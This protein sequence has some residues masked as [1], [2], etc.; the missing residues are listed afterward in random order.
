[1]PGKELTFQDRKMIQEGIEHN[2]SLLS[3]A[4]TI[5]KHRSTVLR[6]IQRNRVVEQID[7]T[8]ICQYCVRNNRCKLKRNKLNLQCASFEELHCISLIEAPYCCNGC[9]QEHLCN[10]RKR[11]YVAEDAQKTAERNAAQKR[12]GTRVK[13]DICH[14]MDRLVSNGK[15]QQMTL[16][17]IY[18]T[19]QSKI[20]ISRRSFYRRYQENK[21][22]A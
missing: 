16:N 4:A 21:N 19:Y 8:E 6:E 18:K 1:M 13:D 17:Q 5:K 15:E 20:P 14:E 2:S 3:I 12:T 11:Y 7:S 9:F 22:N 10:R